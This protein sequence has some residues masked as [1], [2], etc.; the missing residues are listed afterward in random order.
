MEIRPFSAFSRHP[1][2][3]YEVVSVQ[4][5][6]L[7]GVAWSS[8]HRNWAGETGLPRPTK[9]SSSNGYEGGL[10]MTRRY[11]AFSI[12]GKGF[13]VHE[14]SRITYTH[15]WVNHRQMFRAISHCPI[16]DDRYAQWTK[17]SRYPAPSF[18]AVSMSSAVASP[19]STILIASTVNPPNHVSEVQTFL[20][21]RGETTTHTC[22]ALITY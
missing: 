4:A 6:P 2:A 7:G 17:D 11:S 10:E 20:G 22:K 9:S 16:H 12:R 13:T 21:V 5:R 8:S 15:S 14:I 3:M 1:E 19:L 18:I